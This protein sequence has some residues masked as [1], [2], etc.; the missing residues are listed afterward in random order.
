MTATALAPSVELKC[1]FFEGISAA[2]REDILAE[3]SLRNFAPKQ[4]I[5][6]QGSRADRFYLVRS[7]CARF[8]LVTESGKKLPMA[9]AKPGDAVG[10]MA[11]VLHQRNYL[12][13]CEAV[14]PTQVYAWSREVMRKYFDRLPRLLD[15]GMHVASDYIE[16]ML[17]AHT[18]LTCESARER[19]ADVLLG[20][21]GA[22]GEPCS[23]GLLIDATNEEFAHAAH[24]TKYTTCRLLAEW[25]K[26]G[27]IAKRRGKIILRDPGGLAAKSSQ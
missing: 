22:I 7:G 2:D 13:N 6:H 27:V 14:R 8:F 12:L 5:Q 25:Q 4:I 21:G 24:I 23:D 11:V 3:A 16:W 18:S 1:Q 20:Y 9:W 26:T 17:E 10:G 19:L 15:N